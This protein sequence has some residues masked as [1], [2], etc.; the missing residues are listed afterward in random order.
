MHRYAHPVARI[1]FAQDSAES[2]QRDRITLRSIAIAGEKKERQRH[3]CQSS[4]A[5]RCSWVFPDE[6]GGGA[7]GISR[8][9]DES[10]LRLLKGRESNIGQRSEAFLG[11][12]FL[13]GRLGKDG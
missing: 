7:D 11:F 5:N 9:R 8:S 6:F 13:K 1:H 3:R 12:H 10:V 2:I 4:D